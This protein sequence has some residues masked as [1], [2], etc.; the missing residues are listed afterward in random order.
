MQL[1]LLIF[2]NTIIRGLTNQINK[3]IENN[4]GLPKSIEVHDCI[5]YMLPRVPWYRCTSMDLKPTISMQRD[6]STA[7]Q[8]W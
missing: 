3:L 1:F 4:Y 6:T 2:A 7:Q 5:N 8:T